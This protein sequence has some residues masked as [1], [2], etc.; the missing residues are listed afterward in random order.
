MLKLALAAQK[1]DGAVSSSASE[2]IV[3]PPSEA[4]A[5]DCSVVVTGFCEDT[6]EEELI[7]HYY[8]IVYGGG[9]RDVNDGKV[10]SCEIFELA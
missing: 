3:V 9:T 6:K 5:I 8:R 1:Q 4:S 2:E 7:S 10:Q